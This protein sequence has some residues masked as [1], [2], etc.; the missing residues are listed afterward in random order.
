[1]YAAQ[2]NVADVKKYFLGTFIVCPEYDPNKMLYVDGVNSSGIYVLDANQDKGLISL[3]DGGYHLKSPLTLRRQWFNCDYDGGC[4]TMISRIPARMW[5][6]GVSQENTQFTQ[7]STAGGLLTAGFCA[8][9]LHSFMETKEKFPEKIPKEFLKPIALSPL[10]ALR[11]DGTL[12]LLEA[13]VGKFSLSREKGNVLK[14]FMN[15]ALPP[16]LKKH[17]VKY[18]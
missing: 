11:P 15:I 2:K 5:K 10:W 3:E 17:E 18:V 4:A 9:R 13:P 7:L 8:G 14:E 12:H 6:K 16:Q 1:M